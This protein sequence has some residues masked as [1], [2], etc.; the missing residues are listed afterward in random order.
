M[1]TY[2]IKDIDGFPGYRIDTEGQVW[3]GWKNMG[4]K[5][6]IL[7]NDWKKIKSSS[8][9]IGYMLVYPVKDGKRFSRYIHRLVLLTFCGK[10]S[11]GMEANHLNSIRA[12][13]RLS[14]LKWDTHQ[15]NVNE[16]LRI[17]TQTK[18]ERCWNA[19]LDPFKV[20]RIRLIHEIDPT[21]SQR[22]IAKIFNV[23]QHQIW[24]ILTGIGWKHIL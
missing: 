12:D 1:S 14:N 11:A 2:Q 7:S 9:G 8:N 4:I 6:A 23:N 24:R 3:S 17:G 21:L 5:K 19:K 18:G 15:N 22:K 13:N 20:R 16:K 10:P